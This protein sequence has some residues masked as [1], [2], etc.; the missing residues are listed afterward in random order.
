MRHLH[1]SEIVNRCR[2]GCDANC[3]DSIEHYARCP[4]VNWLRVTFLRLPADLGS[5]NSFLWLGGVNFDLTPSR[6]ALWALSLQVVYKDV[7]D[8]RNSSSP[9]LPCDIRPYFRQS[10]FNSA[11]GFPKFKKILSDATR[12][13]PPPASPL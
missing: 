10:C 9:I 12:W 6:I 8:F 5:L 1:S 13:I 3:C 11:R 2:L 4:M 7:N